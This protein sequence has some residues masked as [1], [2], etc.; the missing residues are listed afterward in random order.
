[1][2]CCQ[3]GPDGSGYYKEIGASADLGH[4]ITSNGFQGIIWKRLGGCEEAVH[5]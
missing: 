5:D 4:G 3:V 1:M 2:C